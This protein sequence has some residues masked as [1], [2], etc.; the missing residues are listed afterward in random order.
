MLPPSSASERCGFEMVSAHTP[1]LTAASATSL[2]NQSALTLTGTG[3]TSGD[4]A[5]TV[6]VCGG[7]VCAV[8]AHSATSITCTMPDCSEQ[9]ASSSSSSGG[10]ILVHVPPHGYATAPPGGT[11][12][13]INGI[14][15]VT[16]VRGPAGEAN[17]AGTAAGGVRLTI[18][19]GG[20]DAD[21]A[22]MKV[23]LRQAGGATDLAA[24]NVESSE[25]GAIVCVTAATAAPLTHA[26]L[27]TTVRVATLDA[28]GAEGSVATLASGF[29]LLASG[30]SMTMTAL[31]VTSGSTA[32]GQMICISGTNLDAYTA[33]DSVKPAVTIGGSA[34]CDTA[35]AT[36]T[37]TQLCCETGAAAVGA[38][39]AVAV[40]HP[41]HGFALSANT[42]PSF[43]YVA[44]LELHSID[45]PHGYAGATLA[46]LMDRIATSVT[47][48]VTLGSEP[49]T[50]ASV[51]D[52]ANSMST[53][54]CT[55]TSTPYARRAPPPCVCS[56][57]ARSPPRATS[58]SPTRS[59]LPTWSRSPES[60]RARAPP[61]AA[62]C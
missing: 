43:S 16:D 59:R 48:V 38:S 3:F 15:S 25:S 8:T 29:Q 13:T 19:G 24:C 22:R 6:T 39:L 2:A 45:P 52:A 56:S 55:V 53:V 12:P 28:S 30:A 50:V 27:D 51:V 11:H 5:P 10:R 31:D 44:A 40:H 14:L 49:C 33:Y 4:G 54:T 46:L 42:M 36:S 41:R 57:P 32:G 60:R 34:V 21:A 9:A 62:R 47:P 26:G 37:A 17:P 23:T 18:H 1:T 35:N 20:F 61:A 7:R 58:S